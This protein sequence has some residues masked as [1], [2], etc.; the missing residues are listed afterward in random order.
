MTKPEFLEAANEW[1]NAGNGSCV[2]EGTIKETR[3]I[4]AN[5]AWSHGPG[6][7]AT[8]RTSGRREVTIY[9]NGR[10]TAHAKARGE[11]VLRQVITQDGCT[12]IILQSTT[13]SGMN[14]G[15][16]TVQSKVEANGEYTIKV[17]G[18]SEKYVEVSTGNSTSSCPAPRMVQ[19]P[20]STTLEWPAWTITIKGRL[21]NPRDRRRLFGVSTRTI[22]DQ[23]D[24]EGGIESDQLQPEYMSSFLNLSRQDGTS[25]PIEITTD[26]NLLY[27]R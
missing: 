21:P 3:Q 4:V 27:G 23:A 13:Y 1:L 18:P 19:G 7:S 26:W 16:A 22:V 10:F 15:P 11:S 9:K 6:H 14:S 20:D 25:I 17:T 5:E 12:S 24:V 8:L 2:E